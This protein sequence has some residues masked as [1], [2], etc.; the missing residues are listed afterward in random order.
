MTEFRTFSL[1]KLGF[2]FW[3]K[4]SLSKLMI[5]FFIFMPYYSVLFNSLSIFIS[6]DPL[7]SPFAN[8]IKL[9]KVQLSGKRGNSSS[10]LRPFFQKKNLWVGQFFAMPNYWRRKGVAWKVSLL[11]VQQ[12]RHLT[13]S[14][15]YANHSNMKIEAKNC[16]LDPLWRWWDIDL[17][18]LVHFCPSNSWPLIQPGL[19][20][21]GAML[22][23]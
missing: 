4:N 2:R 10:L 11:K 17:Y 3:P 5:F 7:K 6:S 14:S 1:S 23:I 19:T 12:K 13:P 9:A 21:Y 22:G 15:K 20:N 8:P 18:M 16:F